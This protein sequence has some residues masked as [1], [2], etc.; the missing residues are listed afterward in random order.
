MR[1]LLATLVLATAVG[2]C[3]SARGTTVYDK[4]GVTAADKKTD[5]AQ[6]TQAALDTAG[7]RPAAYLAVD[8]DVVDRCMATRGYR[9]SAPK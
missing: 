2:A 6:C 3:A 1:V 8:R 4:A 5:E 7:P 9:V